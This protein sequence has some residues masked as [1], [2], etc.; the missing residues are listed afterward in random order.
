MNRPVTPFPPGPRPSAGPLQGF[1][2]WPQ[3]PQGSVCKTTL[4]PAPSVTD[5]ETRK[6]NPTF[7][8]GHQ[9]RQ[10][11]GLKIRPFSTPPRP[12]PTLV[13]EPGHPEAP[14]TPAPYSPPRSTRQGR[15]G[16]GTTDSSRGP[17]P[18]PLPNPRSTRPPDPHAPP[19]RS[20]QG[21]TESVHRARGKGRHCPKGMGWWPCRQRMA[22]RVEAPAPARH[23]LCKAR[24]GG[25]GG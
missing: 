21:N 11:P 14:E 25:G 24:R 12:Y 23:I 15:E 18:E 2:R 3:R 17:R 6:Q 5:P 7:D 9:P 8:L 16:S 4:F 20:T 10:M 13:D 19:P 1:P 22:P